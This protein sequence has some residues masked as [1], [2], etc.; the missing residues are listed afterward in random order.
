[1]LVSLNWRRLPARYHDRLPMAGFVVTGA[2]LVWSGLL[3]HSGG[4]AGLWLYA[5]LAVAGGGMAAAFG[6]LMTRVLSR[7]PVALAADASGVVVTVNQLGIVVGIATFGTLYL[8][9]AGRLPAHASS[10][11]TLSSGHAYLSVA[12][13]L[14]ALALAG[15]VLALVHVRAAQPQ[16]ARQ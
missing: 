8:N 2:G 9:L 4:A 12:V 1:A 16:G 6:P 11:F 15:V 3:L 10:A 7:V 13:A 5:A 14:A